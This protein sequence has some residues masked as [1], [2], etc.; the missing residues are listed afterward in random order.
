MS[1]TPDRAM[2]ALTDVGD[3]RRALE[4]R[5]VMHDRDEEAAERASALYEELRTLSGADLA[6]RAGAESTAI[7]TGM[8]RAVL[9]ADIIEKETSQWDTP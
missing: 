3:V 5:R 7:A 1:S 4:Q 9:I 6:V 2:R 8:A